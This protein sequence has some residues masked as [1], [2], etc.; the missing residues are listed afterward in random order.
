MPDAYVAR[1]DEN[2]N[3]ESYAGN[4][5]EESG[6]ELQAVNRA[7]DAVKK[8]GADT[9]TVTIND[10]SYRY[11]YQPD[12]KGQ[13]HLVLLNRSVE[14][15]TVSKL[16]FIFLLITM[17]GLLCM[18]GISVLLAN[19]SVKPIAA[20]WE[21]QKQFVADAS[22]ELKTPLAVISANTEVIMSD[23]QQLVSGQ[24]KWLN[25]IQSE[26]MRMSKL[27]TNLLSVAKLDAD[28]TKNRTAQIS[29]SET[30]S[31]LC[32]VFEPIIYEHN[33]TLNT[34]IQRNVYMRTD[35][36]NLKQLLSILLDNAVQHSVPKAQI[37]V[38]LSKDAQGKIR[39]AVSNTAKPIP[40]E[41]LAHLFDRF[42]RADTENSPNG[43]GLGLSIAQSITKQMGGKLT[44]TSEEN[45]V[46]FIALF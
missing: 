29:V 22:H 13:Y 15:S 16:V 4:R 17:I 21:K 8:K 28:E 35:P 31:N 20:A 11:L 38:S 18:F 43:S 12:S 27:I 39:I 5:D 2:G 37:T 36:D 24:R 42:Y 30:V 26:T 9:G 1:V 3:I 32:L 45:L 14:L 7:M 19:W 40:P 10:D 33:K 23:P 41:Q 6:K 44:V 46:T 25:Y 34:V